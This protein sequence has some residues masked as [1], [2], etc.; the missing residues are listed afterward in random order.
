M[1]EPHDI[2]VLQKNY[3]INIFK[4]PRNISRFKPIY[5]KERPKDDLELYKAINQEIKIESSKGRPVLVIMDSPKHVN[6]FLFLYNNC[7]GKI[8]GINLKEDNESFKYAGNIGRVTIS[9]SAAGRGMDIKPD[10]ETLNVGGLHVIIPFP[11]PNKRTEEQ[12]IGRSGR[13]GQP[14]SATIYRS[15][16]D[17][18]NITPDFNPKYNTLIY[19][20]DTFCYNIKASWPWI[21]SGKEN[22]VKD[23]NYKFNSN[24]DDILSLHAEFIIKP[25][26]IS[27]AKKN[28]NDFLNAIM[29]TIKIS[30][31]IFYGY[32]EWHYKDNINISELYNSYLQKLY[33][34]FPKNC[35]MERCFNHLVAKLGMR[36][37]IDEILNPKPNIN[38]NK[39]LNRNVSKD[40][41]KNINIEYCAKIWIY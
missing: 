35:S 17:R 20:L 12:A 4:I 27:Y 39:L 24:V 10:K 21:Y 5:V 6:E 15:E 11:M 2:E 8:C 16:N 25:S 29:E 33:E 30:W 9:T 13:Q 38:K 31:S 34:F 22:Y 40:N 41:K 37:I 14:G 32:I 36:A 28:K 3:Q 19:Y 23:L 18:Y 1:G 7:Y 26:L